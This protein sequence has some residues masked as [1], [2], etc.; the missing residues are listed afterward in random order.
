MNQKRAT[1]KL[2]DNI[3]SLVKVEDNE[4]FDIENI[5]DNILD[6][7]DAIEPEEKINYY[8]DYLKVPFISVD[9][10][11]LKDINNETVGWINVVGAGIN[12]PYVQTSNNCWL[13]KS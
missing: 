8:Y 2:M 5:P 6:N 4:G 3:N 1:N 12:Y 10:S 13:D 7:E 11:K 9:F